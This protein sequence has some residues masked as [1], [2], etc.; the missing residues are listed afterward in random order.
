MGW[1][2][3]WLPSPHS[4]GESA[5]G[6][7]GSAVEDAWGSAFTDSGSHLLSSLHCDDG[8][9]GLLPLHRMQQYLQQQQ[10]DHSHAAFAPSPFFSTAEQFL[11]PDCSSPHL[12]HDQLLQVCLLH[13]FATFLCV[14]CF[15]PGFVFAHFFMSL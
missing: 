15:I 11:H 2:H 13:E 5:E 4:N 7:L 10:M 14:V 3:H 1:L 9:Q 12:L 8:Q 6:R